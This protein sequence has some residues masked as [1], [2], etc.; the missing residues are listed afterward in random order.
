LSADGILYR[1]L[2]IVLSVVSSATVGVGS[3]VKQTAKEIIN[4]NAKEDFIVLALHNI[5]KS[6][7]HKEILSPNT[8]MCYYSNT[9]RVTFSS[10]AVL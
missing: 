10:T 4:D 5:V 1:Y 3:V 8:V 9:K 6:I 7:I 2:S